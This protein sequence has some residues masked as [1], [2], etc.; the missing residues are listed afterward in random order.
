M[1]RLDCLMRTVCNE[2]KRWHYSEEIDSILRS[3]SF[4]L[5]DWIDQRKG[6]FAKKKIRTN[7]V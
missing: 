1:G 5:L 7:L 6:P 3:T 4:E 2:Q